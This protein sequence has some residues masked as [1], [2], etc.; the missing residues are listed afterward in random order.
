[1]PVST[2][3]KKFFLIQCANT[4][5]CPQTSQALAMHENV[6][7]SSMERMFPCQLKAA[8]ARAESQNVFSTHFCV[9]QA[10]NALSIPAR[11]VGTQK[12]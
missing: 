9:P 2:H 6:K 11:R 3:N 7:T 12:L 10:E 4:Q 1:M 8:F 5:A